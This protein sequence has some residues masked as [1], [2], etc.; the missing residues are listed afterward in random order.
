MKHLLD[1]GPKF[2][3]IILRNSLDFTLAYSF[4]E[5]FHT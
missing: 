2:D 4:E 5:T 3:G 1:N